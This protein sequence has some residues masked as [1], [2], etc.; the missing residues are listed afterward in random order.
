MAKWGNYSNCN[1]KGTRMTKEEG[2]PTASL[3]TVTNSEATSNDAMTRVCQEVMGQKMEDLSASVAQA[4]GHMASPTSF[5]ETLPNLLQTIIGNQIKGAS[6]SDSGA[7]YTTLMKSIEHMSQQVTAAAEFVHKFKIDFSRDLQEAQ[8]N[9]HDQH[10]D[11]LNSIE[12]IVGIVR[13]IHQAK[14]SSEAGGPTLTTLKR[15]TNHHQQL[16]KSQKWRQESA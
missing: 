1:N 8:Q 9:D 10:G 4:A 5:I 6:L 2:H 11:V 12:E 14:Y 7:L 3:S 13:D 15:I 16:E